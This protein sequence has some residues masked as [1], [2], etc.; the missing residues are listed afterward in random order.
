MI[1]KQVYSSAQAADRGEPPTRH[2]L[3]PLTYEYAALEPTIDARTMR[4]H[5]GHHHATYVKKLN[6][7]LDEFPELQDR[8]AIWLLLNLIK[9]PKEIRT[10]VRH[11]AGGHVNHSM[12]WRA[13][14]PHGD[15]A[16][17]GAL[18]DAIVRDF[19]NLERFKA[20]FEEVGS[21]VFG[22]GWVWLA[23]SRLDGGRLQILSTFGHENP[24]SQ[25]HCPILVNDVW[26]HAHY[27]K[28]ENRRED[29]LN[30][31]WKVVN[32]EEAARCY[33]ASEQSVPDDWEAGQSRLVAVAS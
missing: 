12:F 9:V 18:A 21:Q 23:R 24:M 22:S 30:A 26:E 15:V 20:R 13:M 16:P 2:A 3:P 17:S 1:A 11:N 32:W 10:A 28:Y 33:A 27:L 4:L 14:T 31:W 25:G 29:Y 6:A 5:H 8:T 19:G 7:A